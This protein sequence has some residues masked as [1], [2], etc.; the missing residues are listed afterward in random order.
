MLSALAISLAALALSEKASSLAIPSPQQQANPA[1]PFT[2]LT[3]FGDELSDSGSGSWAHGIAG[4]TAQIYGHGTWTNGPVAVQHL[5][6][7]LST[8]LTDYAF[9]G[10]DGGGKSGATI[11]NRYTPADA[12]WDGNP[13]PSVHEQIVDNYTQ[14][15]PPASIQHSLQFLWVGQ[16]DMSM[17]TDPWW[18]EDPKNAL[19]AP[20]F[21]KKIRWHA[22]YLIRAGAPYVLVPNI[23]PKHRSPLVP[24]YLSNSTTFISTW[25]DMIADAN[26]A[27]K[28]SLE[29]SR[30][31]DQIIYYDVFG[32]MLELMEKKDA[33]GLT[34]P[35]ENYCDGI[36]GLD[37]W[38]ECAADGWK[39][40]DAFF[41]MNFVQPTT[42]VHGLVARDM[43]R[44]IDERVRG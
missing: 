3:A 20:T 6:D 16:N 34:Q 12:H 14:P 15:K 18:P 44:V 32:Y 40:A 5:A 41:W 10:A 35:L 4:G 7:L 9:G 1:Y 8:P 36:P 22:E 24:A 43:K 26:A 21:A 42:R 11:N 2:H 31:A 29:K 30:F 13:V 28:A 19:F 27:L 25:G 37:H 23:Y 38:E 17:H 33:F 39:G